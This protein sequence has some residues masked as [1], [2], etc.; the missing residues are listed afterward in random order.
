M[1]YNIKCSL[2]IE[3][4][5]LNW[6]SVLDIYNSV[7]VKLFED[8]DPEGDVVEFWDF[9][10]N[11]YHK[12][13]K[14]KKEILK[15]APDVIVKEMVRPDVC[16]VSKYDSRHYICYRFANIVANAEITHH[17]DSEV[18]CQ[19]CGNYHQDQDFIP[20]INLAK[21]QSKPILM[22][23]YGTLKVFCRPRFIENYKQSGL[24]GL[25]FADWGIS[26]KKG[27]PLAQVRPQKHIWQDRTGVCDECE[28]KTNITSILGVFNTH[29]IFK[30]DFQYVS[31]NDRE[32]EGFIL[33]KRALEFCAKFTRD[34][35]D[36]YLTYPVIPGYMEDKIWPEPKMFTNGEAPL[37]MLRRS[38][39][40]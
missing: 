11:D 40:K 36:D 38:W 23:F 3:S 20:K 7:G 5:T 9:D 25:S 15:I 30:Y 35:V 12:L 10:V 13:C 33:S 6:K 16:K 8:Y 4:S 18:V 26:D 1:G 24:T 31:V 27:L 37:F 2:D 34:S 28:M 39:E 29:E 17:T 14:V 32:G 19:A 22:D 21:L